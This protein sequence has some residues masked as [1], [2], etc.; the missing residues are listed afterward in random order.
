MK[1]SRAI[2][3][4]NGARAAGDKDKESK[5]EGKSTG[6]ALIRAGGAAVAG[7]ILGIPGTLFLT[8]AQT[9]PKAIIAGADA[10]YKEHRRMN[11]SSN[12]VPLGGV[13]FQDS[14]EL[15][16]MRQS[17]MELA[18]MSQYNLEQSLM[19]AEAKHLHR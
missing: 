4:G 8:A 19:G 11:S 1:L 3:I 10:L 13:N 15:A 18:K 6:S 17:G 5:A 7:E 9:A 12:F 2:A 16:T 14:Q